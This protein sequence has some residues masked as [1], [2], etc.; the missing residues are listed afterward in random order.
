MAIKRVLI[1]GHE[2]FSRQL[3]RATL[4][5]HEIEAIERP[6]ATLQVIREAEADLLILDAKPAATRGAL[7][8]AHTI[9]RS[10]GLRHLPVVL[11]TRE[12]TSAER[13]SME[14]EAQVHCLEK[15]FSPLDLVRTVHSL[16]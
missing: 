16:V 8:L 4:E 13:I 15:P 10:K 12:L 11:L 3:L 2:E 14:V 5:S 9:R 1:T 6:V 7:E